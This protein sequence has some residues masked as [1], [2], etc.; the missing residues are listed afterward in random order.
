MSISWQW[1]SPMD[2]GHQFSAASIRMFV[3]CEIVHSYRFNPLI[4]RPPLFASE[5][6]NILNLEFFSM[7]DVCF[8]RFPIFPSMDPAVK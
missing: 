3:A 7:F 4:L 5:P 6:L 8:Q 2:I 1:E